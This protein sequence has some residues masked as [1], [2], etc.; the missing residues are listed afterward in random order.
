MSLVRAVRPALQSLLTKNSQLGQCT[1]WAIGCWAFALIA[2]PSL[3]VVCFVARVVC[4]LSLF[5][6]LYGQEGN[7]CSFH[8]TA[9]LTND[10]SE[11]WFS[12]F[13]FSN[14]LGSF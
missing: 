3:A 12:S 10:L 8:S 5:L 14:L 7:A 13:K 11:K 2:F 9:V 6:L 4:I 1:T